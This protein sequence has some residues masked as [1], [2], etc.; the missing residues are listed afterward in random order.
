MLYTQNNS[1]IHHVR[2]KHPEHYRLS[3]VEGIYNFNK[4]WYS[5]Y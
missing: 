1:N 5:Y 4:F 2:K 3:L